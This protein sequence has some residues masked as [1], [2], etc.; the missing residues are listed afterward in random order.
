[1]FHVKQL[2]FTI[3]ERTTLTMTKLLCIIFRRDDGTSTMR[4]VSTDNASP[5]RLSMIARSLSSDDF[6]I[7]GEFEGAADARFSECEY[8]TDGSRL[9][10]RS[11]AVRDIRYRT[12]SQIASDI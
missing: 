12:I 4:A 6:T 7:M 1:V 10:S 3:P 5:P 9:A 11:L 8:D 2:G